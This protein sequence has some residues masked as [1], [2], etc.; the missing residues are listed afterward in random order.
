MADRQPSAP[1]MALLNGAF[2]ALTKGVDKLS[3]VCYDYVHG[4][5]R[6][7]TMLLEL[8]RKHRL[9]QEDVARGTGVTQAYISMLERGK[10]SPS[11]HFMAD[12]SRYVERLTTNRVGA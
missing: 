9:T 3:L 1:K 2:I 6:E 12:L 5:Y 4:D 10:R 11:S 8:R 7:D